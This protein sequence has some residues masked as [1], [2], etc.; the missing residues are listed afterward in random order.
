MSDTTVPILKGLRFPKTIDLSKGPAAFTV[1][2]DTEDASAIS[3]VTFTL[4][5]PVIHLQFGEGYPGRSISIDG[6][7]NNGDTFTDGTPYIAANT[8]TL[9]T[10]TSAGTYTFSAVNVW[11]VAGN[12]CTYYTSDLHNLGIGQTFTVTGTKADQTGGIL[13]GLS[14]QPT[15]DLSKDL[16]CSMP[17]LAPLIMPVATV[18]PM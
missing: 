1:A 2:V 3:E 17:A 9:G 11:D 16:R 8:I 10:N 5:R 12:L 13:T 7:Y 4:D 15:V 6:Y 14:M 18:S